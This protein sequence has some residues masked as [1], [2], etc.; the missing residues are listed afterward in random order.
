M[1]AYDVV[2]FLTLAVFAL[3]NVVEKNLPEP[4]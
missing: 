2:F 1:P 4:R 3:G